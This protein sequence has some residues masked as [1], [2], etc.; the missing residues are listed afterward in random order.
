MQFK[1]PQTNTI[2]LPYVSPD[3]PKDKVTSQLVR[4]ELLNCFQDANKE[5]MLVL[6]QPV[7]DEALKTQVKEF[8]T[9]VFNNCGVNFEN[10]TKDGILTAMAQCKANAEKMMGSNGANII[11]HHYDEMMKLVAKLP[12]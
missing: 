6:N 2:A 4:D 10:P 7:T 12:E 11:Q 5:F 1:Y 3:I 8:V 9:T